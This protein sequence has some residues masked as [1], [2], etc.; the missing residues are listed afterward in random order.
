MISEKDRKTLEAAFANLT[1]DVR[2]LLF[3]KEDCETGTIA[4]GLAEEVAALSDRLVLEVFDTEKD[5]DSVSEYGIARTPAVVVAGE[6][7][8]G[9]RFYGVPAGHEFTA[10]VETIIAVGV[11]NAM[12]E[13]EVTAELEK[14]NGPVHIEVLVSPSCPY[15]AVAVRTLARFAMVSDHIRTDQIEIGEFADVAEKYNVQGVPKTVVNG[16]DEIFGAIPDIEFA[17]K[18]VESV[19]G[20]K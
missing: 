12:L 15:C 9:I 8:Y 14:I 16:K 10:F 13:P 5:A 2:I 20:G 1:N 17:E 6:S 11:R 7:D 18:I 19:S 3:A 4:R